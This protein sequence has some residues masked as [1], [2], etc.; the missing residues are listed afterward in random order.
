MVIC[1]F[2]AQQAG[3][4][5]GASGTAVPATTV[6]AAAPG[7]ADAS[8]QQDYSAAWAEYYRQQA[9]YYGQAGQAGGPQPGQQVNIFVISPKVTLFGNQNFSSQVGKVLWN[10]SEKLDRKINVY[11]VFI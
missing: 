5:A 10:C 6:A 8:G 1:L 9:A 11:F 7:G 2:P 3:G 4:A